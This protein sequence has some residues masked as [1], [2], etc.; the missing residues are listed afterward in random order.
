[1]LKAMIIDDEE[2]A[3]DALRL[4]IEKFIPEVQQVF[5]C[6]DPRKAA[7]LIHLHQPKLVFLDIR[8]PHIS[9]FHLLQQLPNKNF[10]AIFTTA[11][12]EY[13]IQA[14]R[15]SAF[16]YLLKPIDVEELVQAVQR[17]ISSHEGELH[18][19]ELFDNMV[20]NMNSTTKTNFR[21]ALPSSE[22][23]HF[24]FPNEIIRCEAVGNYTR[25]FASGKRQFLSSKTLG[26]YDELLTP[27]GFIRCHK[28]HLVNKNFI[29]FV[30]HDGYITLTDSSRVEVSRRRKAEVLSALKV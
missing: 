3:T 28:S 17:F 25:F 27:Y 19:K 2:R 12:N 6:N 20:Q 4:M 18:Q 13:A 11:Y 21:L 14:I 29:S 7:E 30:D 10:K 22:G 24:L 9:G 15:F 1:M 23:V 16:D 5:V 26:D 8:M